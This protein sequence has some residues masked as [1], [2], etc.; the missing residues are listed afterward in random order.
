METDTDSASRELEIALD[1]VSVRLEQVKQTWVGVAQ[2]L[3]QRNDMK[4]VLDIFKNI[5][6][7][8][9]SLTSKLGL[10]GSIGL[11]AGIFAG[12]KNI[13]EPV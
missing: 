10:F 3:F 7:A 13:G 5:G 4:N 9:D 2:N 12:V 8:V 11:G 1:T 6:E